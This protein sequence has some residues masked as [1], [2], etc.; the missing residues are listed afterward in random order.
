MARPTALKPILS[1]GVRLF[2]A[3]A[4]VV[5][6]PAIMPSPTVEVAQ[7]VPTPTRSSYAQYTLAALSLGGLINVLSRGTAGR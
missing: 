1:T 2:T 4:I 3:A 5:G 7:S 6:T